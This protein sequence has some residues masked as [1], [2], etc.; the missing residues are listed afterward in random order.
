MLDSD[1]WM[2]YFST[3]EDG[4]VVASS[5]VLDRPDRTLPNSPVHRIFGSS[6]DSIRHLSVDGFARKHFSKSGNYFSP[7]NLGRASGVLSL[8]LEMEGLL[9]LAP[10]FKYATDI[11]Y[12]FRPA[13]FD[14]TSKTLA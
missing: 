12:V 6:C 1:S 10:L 3:I 2:W 9:G 13:R 8:N 14:D 4:V 7:A 11:I 5:I